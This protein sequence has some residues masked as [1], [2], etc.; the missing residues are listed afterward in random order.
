MGFFSCAESSSGSLVFDLNARPIGVTP[1]DSAQALSS[2]PQNRH[3]EFLDPVR[4]I[5]ILLVFAYH[6][7]GSAF[8]RDQLPW[9]HL[10]RMFNVSRSFLVLIPATFGWVGVAIFFVVSGFC[11]HLSFSRSPQW[12]LFFWRRFFRIYPLYLVTLLFFAIVFPTTRLHSL[13]LLSARE[14]ICHLFL[15]HNLDDSIFAINSSYWSIAVEVQLYAL[16][17]LLMV[18]VTR[19]G[20]KYS[21]LGVAAIEITLRLIMGF[22]GIVG[23]RGIPNFVAASPFVYWFSWSLGAYLAECHI[24]DTIYSI[25]SFFLYAIGTLAVAVAF[26]KPLYMMSFPLFAILTAGVISTFLHRREQRPFLPIALRSHLAKAGIWSYSLYLWHQPFVAAVPRF[27]SK[28]ASG[29]HL[30]APVVFVLC[31]PLWIFMFLMARFSFQFFEVPS[32]SVGKHFTRRKLK[33]A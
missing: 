10:F 13:S 17:P 11:I 20:W 7:L 23:G 32:I 15:I 31:V 29:T 8:G 9:G 19:F 5:A 14:L 27:I 26:F 12:R 33:E 1:V 25:S 30:R 3:I 18:L 4:G 6:A 16:Y 28:V 24:R 22:P 2:T 21:L